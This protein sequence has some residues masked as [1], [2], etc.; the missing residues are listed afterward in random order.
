MGRSIVDFGNHSKLNQISSNA[1]LE[2]FKIEVKNKISIPFF[3]PS[4]FMN[5]LSIRIFN[6]LYYFKGSISKKSEFVSYEK[7]FYPLD[8]IL[9]WNR[10]YGKSG[11][12][13]F[14]CVI[15]LENSKEGILELINAIS[16]Y[17]SCSFLAV[18]KRFGKQNSFFSFPTEGYSLAMDF[19]INM[20]N[21]TLM[22]ILDEITIKNGGRF[23]L[24]KDSRIKSDIFYKSDKRVEK[25]KNF[26]K[27]NCCQS[28]S[29]SQSER[30]GL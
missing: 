26:R 12:L 16:N 21:L 8:K 1:I 14:Q 4:F 15:P 11:F 27:N 30:L 10:I 19:P 2:P 25:F 22:N 29:S 13:Q 3:F 23:Y 7:F 5:N 28:F 9:N 6:Q 18:L 24:A 20:K 17:N